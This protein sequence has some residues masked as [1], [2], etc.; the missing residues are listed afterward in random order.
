VTTLDHQVTT[1]IKQNTFITA[2]AEISS[3]FDIEGLL[4]FKVVK[5]NQVYRLGM[6]ANAAN[7]GVYSVGFDTFGMKKGNYA[8]KVYYWNDLE[9]MKALSEV[10]FCTFTIE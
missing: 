3:D 8:V 2:N 10:G 6:V 5:N 4:I 9:N 7:D 1:S